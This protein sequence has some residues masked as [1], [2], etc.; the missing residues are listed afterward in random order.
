MRKVLLVAA[1]MI[2]GCVNHTSLVAGQ[3]DT[4]EVQLTDPP[5]SGLG[6]PANP[7]VLNQ[8]T[9]NVIVRDAL[10][11]VVKKDM[12]LDVFI[13]FG[14][15]KTGADSACGA[16]A[17]G[18]NPIERVQLVAGQLMGHVVQ[19]PNS[20]GAT[21]IWIDEPN[22]HATGASPTIYFRNPL[23]TEV[24]TPP[25]VT[26]MNATFCSPFNNKF[27]IIDKP[28][29]GGQLVVGSV[30]SGAFTIVDTG[31]TTF[32]NI[33]LYAFGKPPPYIQPGRVIKTFSGNYSKFVGFTE[34]NFPLF[35]ADMTAAVDTTV[36]PPPIVLSQA[37]LA[38][39]AKLLG[40]DAGT[41]TYSGSIC[42]PLPPNPNHDVNLQ[43]TID[44][45]NKF[46]EFVIDNDGTCA[47]FTNFTTQLS[48]KVMGSFDPLQNIGNTITVTGMLQNHSGQNP[49]LDPNGNI[50]SCTPQMPCSKGTCIMGEC[51]KNAYNFWTVIP[52]SAADISVAPPPQ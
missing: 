30:F 49:I 43:K 28:S 5:P 18:N 4:L 36:L 25:D 12:S 9:F 14:G 48:A 37:D 35:T 11:N 10:G 29:P 51:Y 50:V 52:R 24:Q 20:Y 39:Q 34:L 26:A 33:Y 31:A 15:I 47:S 7:V 19:L 44:S 17:S 45:W 23:I 21:S 27:V 40:A 42:N 1:V 3:V 22:S 6:S 16:D 13:S 41:V 38:Q 32:N 46:N 2:L 8:A